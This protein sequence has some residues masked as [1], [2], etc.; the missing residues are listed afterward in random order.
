MNSHE[1][2][3]FVYSLSCCIVKNNCPEDVAIMS[4]MFK[5]LGETLNTFLANE[6]ALKIGETTEEEPA[7]C[8]NTEIQP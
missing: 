8:D 1:L 3:L 2:I 6:E 4:S 5:Q 7:E